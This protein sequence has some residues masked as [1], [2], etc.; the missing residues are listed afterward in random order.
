MS[1]DEFARKCFDAKRA[2]YS[3]KSI[4]RRVLGSDTG[5][6]WFRTGMIGLANVISRREIMRK[7]Y[8]TLGA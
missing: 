6:D 4:G 8:R 3:W 7:Q 1:P 2:F 5:L